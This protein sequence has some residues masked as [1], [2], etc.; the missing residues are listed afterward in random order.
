MAREGGELH[1]AKA[2]CIVVGIVDARVK[3]A[4][5][6]ACC[7]LWSCSIKFAAGRKGVNLKVESTLKKRFV[8]RCELAAS[9]TQDSCQTAQ[10]SN[11]K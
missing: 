10:Q 4:Y 6:S 1:N 11:G 3:N 9:T 8:L 2:L 7:M 5:G